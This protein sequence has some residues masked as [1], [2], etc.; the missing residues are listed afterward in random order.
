MDPYSRSAKQFQEPPQ[1]I[2]ATL[3]QLGP[4]M[5]LAGSIVGSGELIMTTKLGAVAGF[6]FLW[7]VLLSCLVKV[8]VQGELARHTISSGKTFLQVF[9]SLPG[10]A[11]KRP[12]WLTLSW[13]AIV[14]GNR[15]GHVC[16]CVKCVRQYEIVENLVG[17]GDV[18]GRGDRRMRC[19]CVR[20]RRSIEIVC[21]RCHRRT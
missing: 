17:G 2:R 4:G 11:M 14:V 19:R 18:D 8:V 16:A 9:N 12:R 10:P 20:N 21:S 13:L 7:F 3:R 1:G 5:I 6:A 15:V